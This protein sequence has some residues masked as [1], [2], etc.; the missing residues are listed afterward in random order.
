MALKAIG[1]LGV[2][3][4]SDTQEVCALLLPFAFVLDGDNQAQRDAS[5]AAVK[6]LN[7]CS[8]EKLNGIFDGTL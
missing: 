1:L 2:M 3:A 5:N 4:D 6:A 8:E 7:R